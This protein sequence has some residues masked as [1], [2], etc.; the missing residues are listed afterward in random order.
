MQDLIQII[1]R[2]QLTRSNC[3]VVNLLYE[4]WI[5]LNMYRLLKECFLKTTSH[6]VMD[7]CKE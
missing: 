6:M 1:V 2:V 5:N 3:C 7:K 4:I